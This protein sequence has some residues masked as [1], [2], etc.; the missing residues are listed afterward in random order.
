VPIVVKVPKFGAIPKF[1]ILHLVYFSKVCMT[2]FGI[3]SNNDLTFVTQIKISYEIYFPYY[4]IS[5]AV[6]LVAACTKK[7]TVQSVNTNNSKDSLTYQPK[8]PGSKWTYQR[9]LNGVSCIQPMPTTRL[10][11]RHH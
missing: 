1:P 6:L 4:F 8:V 5:M 9:S 7:K 10:S 2:Q 11:L 3:Y